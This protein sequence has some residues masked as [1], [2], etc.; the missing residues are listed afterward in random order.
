MNSLLEEWSRQWMPAGIPP[1]SVVKFA[2]NSWLILD[3]YETQEGNT[4]WA[5]VLYWD[6]GVPGRCVVSV[7]RGKKLPDTAGTCA[8]NAMLWSMM[9]N[10]S[11]SEETRSIRTISSAKSA[12]K[13]FVASRTVLYDQSSAWNSQQRPEKWMGSFTAWDATTRWEFRSAE[14]A[15]GQSK[16]EWLLLSESTGTSSILCAPCAKNPFWD[17]VTMREKDSPTASSTSTRY[18][19]LMKL[20]SELVFFQLFGNLCF[21]CG[22]PCCGEVFQALQKTWCV[23]C[24][25]CSFCDKKLDHKWVTL[26][27]DICS[28]C[29]PGRNSM[30][31]IWNQH[32]NDAT[33]V[34]RQNWRSASQR[35]W[36]TVMSRTREDQWVR[37]QSN[38]DLIHFS[39]PTTPQCHC[40][41]PSPFV[42]SQTLVL[43][44]NYPNLSNQLKSFRLFLLSS[45]TV[46]HAL[47]LFYPQLSISRITSSPTSPTIISFAIFRPYLKAIEFQNHFVYDKTLKKLE[48]GVIFPL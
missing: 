12:S 9:D 25:S 8:T 1:A 29:I 3:S 19:T 39:G 5:E 38:Q 46:C 21:K 33:T 4:T 13:N 45:V 23:K 18:L 15:T 20:H 22:D 11:S 30:N 6:D 24:F 41:F 7:M 44:Y 40:S 14:L 27:S 10:T 36:R 2:I 34:S 48:S 26:L 31:S 35:V 43:L 47:Q 42:F 16:S 37:D 32:A 28:K 17:T